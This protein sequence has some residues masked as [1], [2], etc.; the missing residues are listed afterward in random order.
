MSEENVFPTMD[1]H[2]ATEAPETP[3][4]AGDTGDKGP[5]DAASDLGSTGEPHEESFKK[6]MLEERAKRK[7]LQATVETQSREMAELRG[8][9][10]GISQVSQ[11]PAEPEDLDGKFFD[12]PSK[13]VGETYDVRDN[14][15]FKA[16]MEQ[17]AARAARSH[18]DYLD[19]VKRFSAQAERDP[20]AYSDIRYAHDPA[21]Q[22]YKWAKEQE[23]SS[24]TGQKY[25]G[26]T[27][28]EVKTMVK[29]EMA[30]KAKNDV[31][32]AAAE[33]N[34][35]TTAGARGSGR[36]DEGGQAESDHEEPWGMD[37][38]TV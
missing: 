18:D 9:V 4:D 38:H 32:V 33:S 34:P 29:A 8:V 28:E 11:K 30:A 7:Q 17:T 24:S 27:L 15:K 26:K 35:T 31:A 22:F 19:L 13:F 6:G 2:Q 37:L 3:S 14:A 36:G 16:R 1:D 25:E 5:Q 23:K 10:Q 12:G 20:D 21:E